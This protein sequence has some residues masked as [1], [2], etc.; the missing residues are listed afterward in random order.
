MIIQS[1]ILPFEKIRVSI[2]IITVGVL[3]MTI[4]EPENVGKPQI[5]VEIFLQI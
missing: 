2:I 1:I 3:S 4:C 5:V